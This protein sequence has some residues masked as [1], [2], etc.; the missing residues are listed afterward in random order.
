[1]TNGYLDDVKIENVRAWEDQFHEYMKTT[2][3][4]LL[5]TILSEKKLSDET[6]EALKNT[7]VAFKKTVSFQ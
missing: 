5:G 1:V 3:G 7:I 2:Q 6:I 4:D